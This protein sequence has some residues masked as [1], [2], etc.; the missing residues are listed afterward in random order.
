[1]EINGNISAQ[2]CIT[3][4]VPQGSILGPI[5][6][7][8]YV[9]NLQNSTNMKILS[10]ADDTT[11][12]TSSSDVLDLYNM[13]NTEIAKLN[14]WF[15][16]NK[17]SLNAKKT[18]YIIF[19]PNLVHPDI[20]DRNITLNGHMVDRIGNNQPDKSFKFLG[21]YIDETL[22]WK[23]H[24]NNVCTKI[25]RTNYMIN[26][27]KHILPISSLKTLYS[28]LIHS[29]INYGL[30]I[31]GTGHTLNKVYKFQKKSIIIIHNKPYNYHTEPLS[32]HSKI[33]KIDDQ[34]KLNTVTLMH[35][36]KHDK[37]PTSFDALKHMY[38]STNNRFPTRQQELAQCSRFRTTFTST[39]PFHKFPRLW[40]ELLPV[41]H[42]ITSTHIFKTKIQTSLLDSYSNQI[43]CNYDRC[44]HCYPNIHV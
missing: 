3:C 1:M 5:L 11:V 28:S 42:Q 12:S 22:T 6:F 10:F 41:C 8:I 15:C 33:L 40:N 24:T 20:Q 7:L 16:A 13:A 39:I 35:Q 38:F 36:L 2:E 17:L 26:K 30:S 4:G 27:V 23:H 44:K 21:I 18:K 25:P 34:Y 14:D 43:T 37:L 29:H 19:R 9:N 32:K 31:W